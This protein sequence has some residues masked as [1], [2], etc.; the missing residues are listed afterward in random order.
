[1]PQQIPYGLHRLAD[2][3]DR[4]VTEVGVGVVS[5]AIEQAFNAYNSNVDQMM[6]LLVRRT[7]EFKTVYRTA[8][9]AR[10]QPLDEDG[11]ARPVKTGAKYEVAFPLSDWGIAWGANWKTRQKMTVD[12][13]NVT[14]SLLQAADQRRLR[15]LLLQALFAAVDYSY[16][17]AEHGTLTVKPI[18]NGDTQTYNV[19]VGADSGATD[20][21][22]A[23][24]AGTAPTSAMFQ[25]AADDLREHPEN[26]DEV[27]IWVPTAHRAAVTQFSGDFLAINDSNVRLGTGSS[28]LVGSDG[29]SGP[30]ELFGY[31]PSAKTFVREWRSLPQYNFIAMT[32]GGDPPIAM[33]EDETAALRG[34]KSIAEREDHPYWERQYFRSVGFGAF[35]RIGAYILQL[36]NAGSYAPPTGFTRGA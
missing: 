31:V 28:Q 22:Q 10:T 27:T 29:R 9:I 3:K 13:V 2:V 15:D 26:G 1:M 35:N 5:S 19:M 17:D 23:T 6:D 16:E 32:N 34:F 36:N 11:R 33:R 24:N 4:M 12:H 20:N 7:T 14:V 25:A 18:A 30:G 8:G 21:H